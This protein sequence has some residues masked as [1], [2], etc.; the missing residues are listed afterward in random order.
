MQWSGGK[1]RG[2]SEAPAD[3]LYL[4][5]D[6]APDAP[7]VEAQ[8]KDPGSLLN[9][10]KALLRLR[11]TENDL[12]AK[13]NLEILSAAKGSRPVVYRR[14]SFVMG[15]NPSSEAARITG[16]PVEK[17]GTGVFSIGTGSLGSGICTLGP[18]S[19]GIWRI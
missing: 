15:L 4:P 17:S 6:P 10:V 5:V 13:P 19:F 11:R 7:T 12:Q 1:N 16:L 3:E 9:T 14:G 18:Q 2:F 8:E